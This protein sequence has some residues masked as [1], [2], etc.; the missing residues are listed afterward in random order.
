[1]TLDPLPPPSTKEENK[2][3]G[4]KKGEKE[5]NS[6]EIDLKG[7]MVSSFDTWADLIDL[8]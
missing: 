4:E 7:Y 8:P 2:K 6:W 5:G 3:K 1:L